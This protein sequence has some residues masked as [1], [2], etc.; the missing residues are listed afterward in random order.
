M[1]LLVLLGST[2]VS[3]PRSTMVSMPRSTKALLQNLACS[4]LP[5]IRVRREAVRVPREPGGRLF[6]AADR[7]Q[8]GPSVGSVALGKITRQGHFS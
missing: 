6:P 2:R 3:M 7:V 8:A 4:K 1:R 5:A